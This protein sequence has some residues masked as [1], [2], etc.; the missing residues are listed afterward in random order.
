MKHLLRRYREAVSSLVYAMTWTGPDIYWVISRLSQF[1]SNQ[2]QEHWNA[3][4]KYVLRYLK[5]THHYELCYRKC[6]GGLTLVGYSDADWA[7]SIDD[8]R[9]TSTYAAYR[10]RTSFLIICIEI[11]QAV[12]LLY[13]KFC[14][15]LVNTAQLYRLVQDQRDLYEISLNKMENIYMLQG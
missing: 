2:L 6:D 3:V 12:M 14:A 8:R 4:M 15:I 9:R 10:I 13:D 11:I 7:S 5:C 1:L